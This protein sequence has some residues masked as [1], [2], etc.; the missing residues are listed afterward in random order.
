MRRIQKKKPLIQE[1]PEED[2]KLKVKKI[3]STI[4]QPSSSGNVPRSMDTRKTSKNE[5][6]IA[7]TPISP[8]RK[9]SERKFSE[10][11]LISPY[12]AMEGISLESDVNPVTAPHEIS[13]LFQEENFPR[14][15]SIDI[16]TSETGEEPSFRFTLSPPQELRITVHSKIPSKHS[17]P[18]PF[19]RGVPAD[20][21][22]HSLS[23]SLEF[24]QHQVRTIT[25]IP[26]SNTEVPKEL[27]VSLR[28]SKSS[29]VGRMEFPLKSETF[30]KAEFKVSLPYYDQRSIQLIDL[31]RNAI[32]PLQLDLNF[33]INPYLADISGFVEWEVRKMSN[34]LDTLL[35]VR[36]KFPHGADEITDKPV[37]ILLGQELGEWQWPLLRIL[38]EIY[39]EYKGERPR[40]TYRTLKEYMDGIER[41][42]STKDVYLM[43]SFSPASKIEV[44]DSRGV[45]LN[46]LKTF[47]YKVAGRLQTSYLTGLGFLVTITDRLS[48]ENLED[49]MSS[50]RGIMHTIILPETESSEILPR[51]RALVYGV[52]GI[53]DEDFLKAEEKMD[54][55][56]IE[57]T[58]VFSPLVPKTSS[59]GTHY[60]LK[61]AVLLYSFSEIEEYAE[62]EILDKAIELISNQIVKIEEPLETG[63]IPDIQWADH[64]VIEIETLIGTENPLKKIDHT[65]EKYVVS[66][67]LQLPENELWIVLRPVS[68]LIHH[69][70]IKLRQKIWHKLFGEVPIKFK[71]L[72]WE[73]GW[74]LVDLGE[75]VEDIK[76]IAKIKL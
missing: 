42:D 61:C 19:G 11:K 29:N 55:Y 32:A 62:S 31:K 70:K 2:E 68:A 4:K 13:L 17:N 58:K 12:S 25:E 71:V 46:K 27:K 56:L 64:S 6:Q 5:E 72:V 26:L 45:S 73:N 47:I 8:K 44:I 28:V 52:T 38:S 20:M 57:T 39:L 14:D 69:H 1:A 66:G 23:L 21:V 35:G 67:K 3:P 34:V 74:N 30:P 65:V 37:F 53:R 41:V 76:N 50:F 22:S 33:E 43:T 75:F 18:P 49:V 15:L 7:R 54:E 9:T 40:P 24:T 51:Y 60:K 16:R 36:G 59:E 10:I 48:V 63:I